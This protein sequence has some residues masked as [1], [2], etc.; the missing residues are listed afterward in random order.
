[1]IE[2]LT[3]GTLFTCTATNKDGTPTQV[4]VSIDDAAGT[5]SIAPAL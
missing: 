2:S 4:W 5:F 3:P 1:V